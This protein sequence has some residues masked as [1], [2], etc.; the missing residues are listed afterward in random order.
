MAT[1]KVLPMGHCKLPCR[2]SKYLQACKVNQFPLIIYTL[3]LKCSHI[4]GLNYPNLITHINVYITL[5]TLV[6]N[7]VSVDFDVRP[8]LHFCQTL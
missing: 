8:W 7:Q 5:T 1:A 6:T 2:A 3:R 4:P